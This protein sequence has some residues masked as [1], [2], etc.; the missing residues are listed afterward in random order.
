MF[1]FVM[2]MNLEKFIINDFPNFNFWEAI[3]KLKAP[4]VE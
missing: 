2:R 3:P 1:S 4:K